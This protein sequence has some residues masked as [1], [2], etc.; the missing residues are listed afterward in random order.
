M[1]WKLDGHTHLA[2]VV[3]TLGLFGSNAFAAAHKPVETGPRSKVTIIASGAEIAFFIG[4]RGDPCA[5][6][7]RSSLFKVKRKTGTDSTYI[8]AGQPTNFGLW[9]RAPGMHTVTRDFS[10]T[11]LDGYEY[12]FAYRPATADNRFDFEFTQRSPDGIESKLVVD[13]RPECGETDARTY[14]AEPSTIVQIGAEASDSDAIVRFVA[15]G[16]RG[17]FLSVT[18][19]DLWAF[20]DPACEVSR[21]LELKPDDTHQAFRV[22]SNR[23]WNFRL[24]YDQ[25]EFIGGRQQTFADFSLTPLPAAEYV[26]EYVDNP[27]EAE[28]NFAALDES[29]NRTVLTTSASTCE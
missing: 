29:G 26:I 11:P 15:P 16:L 8:V 20:E 19:I 25:W 14:P 21:V 17:R 3:T 13:Y 24:F 4:D 22:P 7:R 28:V 9:L 27:I 10:F 6:K 18:G 2:V 23:A 12:N 1:T 5:G